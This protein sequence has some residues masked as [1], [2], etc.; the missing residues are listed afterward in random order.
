MVRPSPLSRQSKANVPQTQWSRKPVACGADLIPL[1]R[2]SSETHA[3]RV[4]VH[5]IT[6]APPV[7]KARLSLLCRRVS[8]HNNFTEGSGTERTFYSGDTLE[9]IGA[10]KAMCLSLRL[11]FLCRVSD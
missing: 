10:G 7:L 4:V 5:K 11:L 3:S 9:E 1:N 8:V 2:L 6:S